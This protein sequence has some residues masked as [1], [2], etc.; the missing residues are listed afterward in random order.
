MKKL[1]IS[2]IILIV[3]IQGF[4][5]RWIG[6]SSST[7]VAA[8]ISLVSSDLVQSRVQFTL[9]GF[10][11]YE[12]TT[13]NGPAYSVNVKKGSPME[14]AGAPD[15]PKLTISLV[16]PDNAGMEAVVVS[17]SYQDFPG[18]DIAPSKGVITRDIDPASVPYRYGEEYG[19]DAFFPG[20][21]TGMRDPYILRD[22][23]GQTLIVY[24]FQYNPLTKV[25]RV[26]HDLTIEV[27]KISDKGLN[28]MIRKN[29]ELRFNREF[30]AIYSR[31]FLNYGSLTY[32]PLTDL[33]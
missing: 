17:S 24:P 27:R 11:L 5:S 32:T 4:S 14:V 23:R 16:I 2:L 9:A 1:V 15:L 19:R 3:A 7:P 28:P 12:V 8:K 30:N 18:M 31:H 21:I 6:I 25:L 10:S 20:M 22:L 13:P 26:Y 29:K 33:S